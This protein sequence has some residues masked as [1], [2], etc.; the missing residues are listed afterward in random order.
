MKPSL[1]DKF[2]LGFEHQETIEKYGLLVAR[3]KEKKLLRHFLKIMRLMLLVNQKYEL[4]I[5]I[6]EKERDVK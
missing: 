6:V 3:I 2:K 4:T 1:L 5:N